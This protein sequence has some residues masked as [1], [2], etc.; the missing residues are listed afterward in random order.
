MQN[1]ARQATLR[2]PA[3]SRWDDGAAMSCI[4]L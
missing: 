4:I 2:S 1:V 3:S